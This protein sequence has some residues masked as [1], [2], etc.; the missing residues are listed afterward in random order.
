MMKNIGSKSDKTD[1]ILG[2]LGNYKDIFI[3]IYIY[4]IL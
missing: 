3:I 4:F 1:T 2:F